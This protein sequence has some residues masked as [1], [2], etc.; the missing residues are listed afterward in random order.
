[1][2]HKFDIQTPAWH[3]AI[4]LTPNDYIPNNALDGWFGNAVLLC[5]YLVDFIR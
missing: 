5:T 3:F 4:I 2:S 1:M